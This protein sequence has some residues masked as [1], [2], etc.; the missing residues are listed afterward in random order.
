SLLSDPPVPHVD[1]EASH[2]NDELLIHT[3]IKRVYDIRA[4]DA[5]LRRLIHLPREK[6]GHYFDSLRKNYPIR[7]EFWNTRV[8]LRNGT[9]RQ[10]EKL[11]ILG[12]QVNSED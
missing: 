1:V 12:F 3:V 4:D 9:Q 5:R 11:K 7:R 2:K 6:R 8:T 10:H